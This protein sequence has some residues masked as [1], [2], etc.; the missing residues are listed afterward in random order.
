MLSCPLLVGENGISKDVI[1]EIGRASRRDSTA[2]IC[3]QNVLFDGSQGTRSGYEPRRLSC[4]VEAPNARENHVQV[5]DEPVYAEC[6]AF[7]Q[8]ARACQRC[9]RFRAKGF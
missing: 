8:I 7:P 5:I 3:T 2:P 1:R 6:Q 9:A 4:L